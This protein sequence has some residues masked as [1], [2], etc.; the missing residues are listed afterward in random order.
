MIRRFLSLMLIAALVLALCGA[1]YA[2]AIDESLFDNAPERTPAPTAALVNAKDSKLTD[3]GMLRVWLRSLGA[4]ERL[5]LTI[6][7]PYTIEHD[8]GF[9]FERDAQAVL[10]VS[11]GE[12]YMSVSGLTMR[13]GSSV[14]FTRQATQQRV[15]GL[16]IEES[17]VP[18]NLFAGDLTVSV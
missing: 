14:T 13:M 12:I 17:R 3:D 8:S 1:A 4:P 6:A 16:Y 9:R 2:T 5:T 15:N 10:A 11:N 18:E 7:G